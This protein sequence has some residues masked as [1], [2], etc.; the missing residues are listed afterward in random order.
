M[1]IHAKARRLMAQIPMATLAAIFP[2]SGSL[3][4]CIERDLIA[5]KRSD[6]GTA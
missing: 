1:N 6:H 2:Q 3:A 4:C 5:Q